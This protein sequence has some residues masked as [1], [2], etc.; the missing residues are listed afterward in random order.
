MFDQIGNMPLHP[1]VLHGA[2]VGIPLAVLLAFLFA[3]PRTRAWARWA[4]GLTVLGATAATFVTKESGEALQ[5]M[6]NIQPGNAAGDLIQ[7]HAQLADQLFI[8][9]IIFAVI[10]VANV[11]LVSRGS[12]AAGTTPAGG[13]R[14]VDVILPALLVVIAVIAMIWVIRVGD[15]GSRAVWNP[16]GAELFITLPAERPTASGG[17]AAR[18]TDRKSPVSPRSGAVCAHNGPNVSELSIQV[19]EFRSTGRSV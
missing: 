18:T 4:F 16:S 3:F 11:L 15:L 9:M 5:R 1:L 10:G 7:K 12:S 6:R 14:L 17:P 13:Q 2:V 19:G 8:I